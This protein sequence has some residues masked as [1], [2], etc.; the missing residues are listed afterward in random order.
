MTVQKFF[1]HHQTEAD[2]SMGPQQAFTTIFNV[3]RLVY[4]STFGKYSLE[5]KVWKNTVW[6]NHQTES[7]TS[8]GPQLQQAFTTLS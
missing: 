5:T 7:D 2:T 8:M 1:T 3:H 6:K 4:F